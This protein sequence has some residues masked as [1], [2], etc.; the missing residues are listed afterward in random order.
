MLHAK[1]VI[2][3]EV[4]WLVEDFEANGALDPF[5]AEIKKQGME[6]K[7]IN[8]IPF[9]AGKYDHFKN[10]DCVVFFGS[11][12]LANQLQREKGWIPGPIC[13]FKNLT[14][15]TYYSYWGK[16]LLNQDYIMLPLLEFSRRRH[17]IYCKFGIDGY[18]FMRPNSGAKTFYGNVYPIEELDKE[19]DLMEG[20]AAKNLDEIVVVL[21]SPKVI[22]K[23]WRVI[24][25][26]KLVVTASQY[27][28]KNEVEEKEGCSG[29]IAVLN[30]A[31]KIANEKWQP[32]KAYTLDIC[33]SN[34]KYYL[35]EAN[36]FSCSGL[37]KCRPEP[38]V[39]SVS[40]AALEEWKEYQG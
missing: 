17:E 20:Y 33:R 1:E 4:K 18:I 40:I 16:Y 25:V 29:E 35:L 31:Q 14:C 34:G 19:I 7:V 28:V 9:E 6:C 10:E 15:S 3:E 11:L 5:I 13:N 23:E 37:Y 24:V 2:M 12:N 39:T 26:D 36:S 22:D 30:Y 8:Y 21:S 38:I 32:D 27:K